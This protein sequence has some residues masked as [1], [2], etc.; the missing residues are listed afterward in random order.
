[1]R[2]RAI[3]ALTDAMTE[4]ERRTLLQ[5]L[6]GVDRTEAKKETTRSI[7]E[8]VAAA[9]LEEANSFKKLS[10]KERNALQAQAEE[11]AR[12][13]IESDLR[14]QERKVAL[15]RWKRD[16]AE[17]QRDM[18]TTTDDASP[19]I[20]EHP[21]L[22]RELH[23][24]GTKKIYSVPARTLASLP[25]WRKQRIYRH[26]RAKK[27]AADKLK[28]A[29]LGMPGTIVLHE[30]G[31]PKSIAMYKELMLTLLLCTDFRWEV[32]Y[33]GWSASCGGHDGSR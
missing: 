11:A 14:I 2:L 20:V 3:N 4:K 22:G 17:E 18:A 5:K 16:L 1:M 23:D 33:S 12:E 26:D 19:P 25:V 10:E 8:A 6:D 31:L 32:D 30:V 21:L 28:T 29:H 13:R 7:G 24:F 27:I 9:K 15:E